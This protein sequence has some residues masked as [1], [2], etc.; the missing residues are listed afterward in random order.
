MDDVD[1]VSTCFSHQCRPFE[2]A[3]SPAD[4]EHPLAAHSIERNQIERVAESRGTKET[5][6]PPEDR[7]QTAR[8]PSARTTAAASICCP[9]AVQARPTTLR[10]PGQ[11][12]DDPRLCGQ[13]SMLLEP[14]HISEI[15]V[16]ANGVI[17]WRDIPCS[18]Q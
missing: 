2:R 4:D 8:N 1:M 15:V 3:L 10:H 7:R 13:A 6:R 9:S 14:V 18:T 17:A 11:S 5:R 12:V 16:N